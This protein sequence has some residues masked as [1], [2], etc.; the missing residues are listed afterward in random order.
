M[1]VK[2]KMSTCNKIFPFLYN[3][4]SQKSRI[5]ISYDMFFAS[6]SGHYVPQLAQQILEY[7]SNS[8]NPIIKIKGIMVRNDYR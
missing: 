1:Q 5:A 2:K 6:S 4:Q 7:N 8:S 3:F